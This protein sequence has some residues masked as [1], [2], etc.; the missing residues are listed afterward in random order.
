MVAMCP[1]EENNIA[2]VYSPNLNFSTQN[3]RSLNISTKNIITE[4]KILAIVKGGSD[5]IFSLILD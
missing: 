2:N 1:F 3:V 5:I 4:Q